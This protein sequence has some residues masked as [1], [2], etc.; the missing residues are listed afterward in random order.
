MTLNQ[1]LL[2]DKIFIVHGENTAA[3]KFTGGFFIAPVRLDMK[4]SCLS[5]QRE[6]G[7]QH[8]HTASL[9][10]EVV[11]EVPSQGPMPCHV[12]VT[13]NMVSQRDPHAQARVK[14][15]AVKS[16]RRQLLSNCA[17]SSFA[18]QQGKFSNQLYY[19]PPWTHFI[20]LLILS[21]HK[22]ETQ[23]LISYPPALSSHTCNNQSWASLY[24]RADNFELPHG[25][26]A[27]TLPYILKKKNNN[28]SLSDFLGIIQPMTS[29]VEWTPESLLLT[30]GGS[31]CAL[32]KS[33]S[34]YS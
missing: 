26:M 9:W 5:L 21:N 16:N 10:W 20:L 2:K 13:K 17:V 22:A 8:P 34:S 12:G 14:H 31:Y 19:Y 18:P 15:P 6:E 23:I 30:S 32:T 1:A 28:N 4:T 27:P 24:S 3:R 29:Q 25:G 11:L 7:P 33:I